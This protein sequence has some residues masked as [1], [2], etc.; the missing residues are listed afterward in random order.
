MFDDIYGREKKA[1]PREKTDKESKE[2]SSENDPTELLKDTK[3]IRDD[4][5]RK[6]LLKGLLL[7]IKTEIWSRV[8]KNATF[9]ELCKAILDA[10]S[11]VIQKELSEDKSFIVANI[12][13]EQIKEHE[14]ELVQK[15]T[16]IDLLKD[17]VDLLKSING[18]YVPQEQAE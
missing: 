4:A 6:I 17:Q 8:S 1:P 14:K 5:K 18:K 11:I 15:Q 16:Q 2:P 9:E 13:K 7:K 3:R 12:Q 10:E